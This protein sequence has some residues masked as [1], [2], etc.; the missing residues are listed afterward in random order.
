[1]AKRSGKNIQTQ[2]QIIDDACVACA[3][4][5]SL[6][7]GN[8]QRIHL[9]PVDDDLNVTGFDGRF[10]K[11]NSANILA[12]AQAYPTKIPGDYHHAS[13]DA[14]ETGAKAP[15]SGW[16]DPASITEESNGIWGDVQWTDAAASAIRK[17]EFLY[18]S[19]VFSVDTETN[20]TFALKGF[21]LT[22]YP[23]LGELTPV[24]NAQ[25]EKKIMEESKMEELLERF[26][27]M[28]N[29]PELAT[30]EEVIAELDKALARLHS[31]IGSKSTEANTQATSLIDLIQGLED[32]TEAVAANSQVDANE[33]VPR[34]EFDRLRVEHN[35]ITSEREKDR[36]ETAVNAALETGVIAPASVGWATE[37]CKKDAEG[38]AMFVANSAQVVPLGKESAPS[39]TSAGVLSAEETAV[40][41]QL[42]I[43]TEDYLKTK[44]DEVI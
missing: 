11:Y 36:V 7:D 20:E 33:F 18:I 42:G 40:C 22:H 14:R 31:L 35:A 34:A 41:S 9:I 10:W 37:Y 27:Y 5:T 17:K 30:D 29:L 2:I 6:L 16:L 28:L 8:H 3:I 13:L 26:K 21:A 43:S 39:V 44:K 19:P 23:N 15:A 4:D 25:K 24:A 1:M 12:N 32:Q 38:F